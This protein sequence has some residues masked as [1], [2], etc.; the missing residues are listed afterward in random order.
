MPAVTFELPDLSGIQSDLDAL[1]SKNLQKVI[2][3]ALREAGDYMLGRINAHHN[4][5][6]LRSYMRPKIWHGERG[7]TSVNIYTPYRSELGIPADDPYY[8]P[9]AYEYGFSRSTK[10]GETV[11]VEG[12]H[13]MQRGFAESE[14]VIAGN[15]EELILEKIAE[16]FDTK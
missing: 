16:L 4:S 8:W 2:D 13:Y 5:R 12:A 7:R 9:S 10:N 11:K 1:D 14:A 3:G 6:R 15:I